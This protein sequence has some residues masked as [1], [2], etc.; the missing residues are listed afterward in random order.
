MM[1]NEF[2]QTPHLIANFFAKKALPDVAV[3]LKCTPLELALAG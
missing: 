3:S 2:W 1:M